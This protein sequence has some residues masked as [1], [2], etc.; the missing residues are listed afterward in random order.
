M[1]KFITTATIDATGQMMPIVGCGQTI[2]NHLV[3]TFISASTCSENERNEF[4]VSI[5]SSQI[6][7]MLSG[8]KKS[9]EEAAL[10]LTEFSASSEYHTSVSSP[11]KTYSVSVTMTDL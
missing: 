7:T 5:A 3:E 10:F 11:E 8:W 6:E 4:V 1:E 2:T 9:L